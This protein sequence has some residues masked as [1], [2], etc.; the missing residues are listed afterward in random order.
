MNKRTKWTLEVSLE[1]D[2][3]DQWTAK[4]LAAKWREYIIWH[5]IHGETFT[6][7]GEIT[8]RKG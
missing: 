5:N 7:L 3:L 2:T 4:D 8:A 1:T 6:H